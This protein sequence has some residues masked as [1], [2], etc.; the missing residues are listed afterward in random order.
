MILGDEDEGSRS[1][2]VSSAP[3]RRRSSYSYPLKGGVD[4]LSSCIEGFEGGVGASF[5][6]FVVIALVFAQEVKTKAMAMSVYFFKMVSKVSNHRPGFCRSRR[7]LLVLKM[8]PLNESTKA[9]FMA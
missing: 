5:W 2:F 7:M 8:A 9:M 4:S 6:F 1:S 3:L